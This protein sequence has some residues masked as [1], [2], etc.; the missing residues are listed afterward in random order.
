MFALVPRL[1]LGTHTLEALPPVIRG[2]ASN[3]YIPRQ[4]LG[5]SCELIVFVT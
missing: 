1:C 2:G 3:K 5:M 4:S